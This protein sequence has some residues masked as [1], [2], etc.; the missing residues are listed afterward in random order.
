MPSDE[1]LVIP[2]TLLVKKIDDQIVELALEDYVKGVVANE[3]GTRKPLESLK[4]QAIAARTFACVTRRHAREG[5]DLCATVHC[6]V[7]NPRVRY[8]DADQA[9][10]ET[11]G[12]VVSRAGRLVSTPFFGHCDGRTRSSEEVWSGE[13]RHCRSVSCSC[14]NTRLYGHGVGMCQRGAIAM[15]TEGASAEEILRHYYTG[16]EIVPASSVPRGESRRSLVLGQVVDSDGQGRSGLRLV[17][18]GT[19]GRLQKGTTADGRFWFSQLPADRWELKVKGKPVR[20]GDLRTDGRN[21][22]H[23]QVVVPDA[24]PV[25]VSTIPLAYPRLL[26]GTLGYDGV[27]VN[28]SDPAG[29]EHNVLSGSAPDFNPGGFSIPLPHAG[30]CTLRLLDQSYEVEI[31]ETGLWVRFVT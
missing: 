18:A 7:W 16:V 6:Q 28:I 23:V 17:L 11:T 3:L 14:G 2:E 10:D 31:P 13:M 15:A 12:I 26:A 1:P 8:N 21:T 27:P 29:D 30:N 19:T 20:Y 22:L 4:A 24:P 25:G 5:F 9:V